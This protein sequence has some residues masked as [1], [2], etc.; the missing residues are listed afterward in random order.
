MEAL[1]TFVY[2]THTDGLELIED[3]HFAKNLQHSIY[4]KIE[5]TIQYPRFFTHVAVD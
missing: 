2:A 4:I 1:D 5:N 3:V